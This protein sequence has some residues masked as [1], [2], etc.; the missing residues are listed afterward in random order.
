MKNT[1]SLQA[2]CEEVKIL[3]VKKHRKG[4]GYF[5]RIQKYTSRR[6]KQGIKQFIKKPAFCNYFIG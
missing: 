5:L 4:G 3:I 1:N 6:K 2:Y